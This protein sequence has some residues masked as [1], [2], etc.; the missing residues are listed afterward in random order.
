MVCWKVR[1]PFK[2]D[3]NSKLPDPLPLHK[4]QETGMGVVEV[5]NSEQ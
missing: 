1:N 3:H 2:I 5:K 4:K